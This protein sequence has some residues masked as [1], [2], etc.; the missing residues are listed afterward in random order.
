[1]CKFTIDSTS[2][3]HKADV[4]NFILIA[5]KASILVIFLNR[6]RIVT[7]NWETCWNTHFGVGYL[8]IKYDHTDTPCARDIDKVIASILG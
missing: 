5:S 4:S 3:L 1:M 2:V 6:L 8:P 7:K